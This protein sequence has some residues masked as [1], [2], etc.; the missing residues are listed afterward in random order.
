MNVN[1]Q[2]VEQEEFRVVLVLPWSGLIL[3]ERHGNSL[4]LPRIIITSRARLAYQ[5]EETARQRWNTAIV[6]IDILLGESNVSPCAVI[7]VRSR[8]WQFTDYGLTSI[9]IEAF[10]DTDLSP[11]ECLTIKKIIAGNIESRGPFSRIGWLDDAQAWVRHTVQDDD[12]RFDTIRQYTATGHFALVRFESSRGS[13][14][15]MKAVGV[16]NTHE[17]QV[18]QAITRC[19]PR[20][21]PPI[22]AVR[23]D[24]NAW[25]SVDSGQP[26]GTFSCFA[27]CQQV[28]ES[29]AQMQLASATHIEALR[30]NGCFDLR[31]S[32]V[33]RHMPDLVSYLKAA[34]ADQTSAKVEPIT[35]IRLDEL[36]SLLCRASEAIESF[37]IPNTLIHNDLNPGNILFDGRN[38]VFID[39]AEACIGMPWFT[40]HHLYTEVVERN[41][42]HA[43]PVQLKRAYLNHWRLF[44]DESQ[45]ERAFVLSRPLGIASYLFGRDP[46]F[47]SPLRHSSSVQRYARSLARHIDRIARTRT[48]QEALCS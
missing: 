12:L 25:I 15:W 19:C 20:F 32:V 9:P 23:S 21:V 29:L 7:E 38:A 2:H 24:W 40:F 33:L 37:G 1:D 48:F 26:V 45:M 42:T 43:N 10:G 4:P 22:L 39:W 31:S 17:L 8:C 16:P 18:T 30:T 13:I 3:A 14:Y 6:V 35:P 34:M 11:S 47:T 36:A 5:F 46:A 41:E 44:L 28:A 27:L